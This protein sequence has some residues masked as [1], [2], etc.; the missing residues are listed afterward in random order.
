M[1][2]FP[3]TI[4]GGDKTIIMKASPQDEEYFKEHVTTTY[5]GK[6]DSSNMHSNYNYSIVQNKQNIED[7][8]KVGMKVYMP[9][10]NFN[11]YRFQ[12]IN[13]LISNKGETP[14]H[15]IS[16]DRL[17]G[18]WLI[19]DVSYAQMDG[20]FKQMLTLVKREL[21]LSDDELKNENPSKSNA[22][23][24]LSDSNTNNDNQNEFV[25]CGS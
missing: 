18:E 4:G 25:E 22:E 10:P 23:N 5:V 8:Q 3:V 14:T 20:K 15:G 24:S 12:K 21:G 17:S 1:F 9:S 6:L 16:N 13:V 19:I 7:I 2:C 11:L